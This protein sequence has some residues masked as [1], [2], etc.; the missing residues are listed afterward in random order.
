M[1]A[2]LRE[3]RYY[4]ASL[5][6]ILFL[7]LTTGAQ[8]YFGLH[9]HPSLIAIF[10]NLILIFSARILQTKIYKHEIFLALFHSYCCATIAHSYDSTKSFQFALTTSSFWILL[11]TLKFLAHLCE[12][13]N[14]EKTFLILGKLYFVLS[15]LFYAI[16]LLLPKNTTEGVLHFGVYVGGFYPRMAGMNFDPNTFALSLIPF[17]FFFFANRKFAW[18]IFGFVLLVLS[19]SRGGSVAFLAGLAV[20]YFMRINKQEI[21]LFSVLITILLCLILFSYSLD[22]SP[23]LTDI[24]NSRF[25]TFSNGNGRTELWFNAI[26]LFLEKP[27]FGWGVYTYQP[28]NISLFNS[29][30]FSHNTYIDVLV[31]TGIT[32]G[33][34]FF[35]FL[36]LVFLHLRTIKKNNIDCCFLIPVYWGFLVNMLFIS[37][38]AN[39]IFLFFI[40]LFSLDVRKKCV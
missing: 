34:L 17:L 9:L 36:L 35:I 10:V 13:R 5:F 23:V 27:I 29:N 32:G 22:F 20:C 11:I 31:E 1:S 14:F 40:L 30:Y 16:G 21:V 19:F 37:L 2:I 4:Q 12:Y 6:L 7:I 33:F 8:D 24:I 3:I 15:F 39:K 25:S 28:L 26:A 18:F 38:H